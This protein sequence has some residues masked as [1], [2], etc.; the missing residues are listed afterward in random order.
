MMKNG[1]LTFFFAFCPGAGQ[2]YQ[3]YMKRGLSL[4]TMFCL[5]VA[6]GVTMLDVLA[7][8][9]AIVWM[10]SFFDTLN[11]RAQ[12]GAGTAP[13]DDYLVHIN[14]NDKRME[15]FMMDS[16]KLVGW[17]LIAL[18]VL[19]AYK[20]IIMNTLGDLVW[21][22]GKEIPFFRALYLVLDELP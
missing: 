21:R 7:V 6:A 2:M 17:G 11:L 22:W 18:G 5:F 20:N 3:G 10:Y 12:I 13:Q 4:I 16:H 9:C 1:I 15:Q 19:V 14:W 8:G